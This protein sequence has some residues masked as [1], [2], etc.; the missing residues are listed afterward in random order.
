VSF[1]LTN[2]SLKSV[3]L[4]PRSDERQA[5][6]WGRRCVLVLLRLQPLGSETSGPH[7]AMIAR[8]GLGDNW[9]PS[10]CQLHLISRNDNVCRNSSG[11][12]SAQRRPSLRW[13]PPSKIDCNLTKNSEC[14]VDHTI[15]RSTE[16]KWVISEILNNM[17]TLL[18]G[19]VLLDF[20]RR[21]NG[22]YCVL[23]GRGRSSCRPPTRRHVGQGTRRL[24][25]LRLLD[26]LLVDVENAIIVQCRS[27]HGSGRRRCWPPSVQP[28]HRQAARPHRP[29][30]VPIERR[31]G[32]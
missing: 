31:L 29:A 16:G 4:Q 21:L 18:G 2:S 8:S 24:S 7:A 6:T 22:F 20:A 10:S 23:E 32:D 17:F 30:V 28:L 13:K 12:T 9:F 27:D 15:Q 19:S 25:R 26:E 5:L 3:R 11:V 14:G 1:P